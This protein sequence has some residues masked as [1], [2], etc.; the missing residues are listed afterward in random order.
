[1]SATNQTLMILGGAVAAIVGLV[2]W[3]RTRDDSD[4]DGDDWLPD[5]QPLPDAPVPRDPATEAP[6]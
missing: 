4:E 6:E 1:M 5:L 2:V 3:D